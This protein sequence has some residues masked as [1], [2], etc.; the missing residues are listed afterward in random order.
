MTEGWI[1]KEGGVQEGERGGMDRERE[2]V[3]EGERTGKRS[4]KE[5]ENDRD[6][7]GAWPP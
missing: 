7:K 1:M 4:D 6:S 3:K 2:K 5:A